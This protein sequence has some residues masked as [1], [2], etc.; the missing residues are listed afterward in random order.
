[1]NLVNLVFRLYDMNNC[2]PKNGGKKI[3]KKVIEHINEV[4]NQQETVPC[5]PP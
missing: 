1:M 3:L 2:I 5:I 4:S